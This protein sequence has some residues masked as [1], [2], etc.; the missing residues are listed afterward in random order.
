MRG[1]D[2]KDTLACLKV[3]MFSHPIHPLLLLCPARATLQDS[4]QPRENKALS[5]SVR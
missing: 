4:A 1:T 5:N 3:A 2:P